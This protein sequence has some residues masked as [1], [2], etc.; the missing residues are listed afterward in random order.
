MKNKSLQQGRALPP[1]T[2]RLVLAAL[3]VALALALQLLEA[4]MP[5]PQS[6]PGVKLGLANIVTLVA[7][8]LLPFGLT[9]LVVVL[10]CLA[11]ALLSGSLSSLLFSLSGGLA[12]L[13]LMATAFRWGRKVFSLPAIS[14]IGALAHNFMQ[15]TV[16]VLILGTFGVSAYLPIL[17][18]SAT[19][20]GIFTGF[21]AARVLKVL[22]LSF[23]AEKH[24]SHSSWRSEL[25]SR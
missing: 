9:A 4:A 24:P 8:H 21:S 11:A 25:V 15:I 5:I 20:T 16:A 6:A 10:R 13:I 17:V 3:L 23:R 19:G 1:P 22:Q 12:S 14:I 18:L 7:L 2:N